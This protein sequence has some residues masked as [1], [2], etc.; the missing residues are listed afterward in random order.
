LPGIHKDWIDTSRLRSDLKGFFNEKRKDLSIFG[1]TVNQ[2]F[3]AFVF[4]SVAS[5]Y[6]E[7]GW[8]VGFVHPRSAVPTGKR[9]LRLKFSTRGRPENYSYAVC[10]K[11]EE[12]LQVRHQL[13]VATRSFKPTGK[14]RANVVLDVAVVRDLD[15]S[16]YDTNSYVAN[17]FLVSF[18]EAKHMSAFAE[19]IASFIGIV[20]EMQPERLTRRRFKSKRSVPRPLTPGHPSPFLFVSGFLFHTAQGLAETIVN[21]GFDLDIYWRAKQLTSV[22]TVKAAP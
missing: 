21:R 10:R 19:L 15:L 17:D 1:S 6:R 2:T 11:G 14:Y 13:R 4:A 18:G 7:R 20:H 5:W 16:S 12:A 8:S 9:L 3:E 22:V